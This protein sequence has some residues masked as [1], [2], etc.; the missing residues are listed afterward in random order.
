MARTAKVEKIIQSLKARNL[1][2]LIISH[3]LDQ[4]F[5]L[6][7]RICVLRRGKQIGIRAIGQDGQGRDLFDDHWPQR[8]TLANSSLMARELL[9]IP[10]AVEK[11]LRENEKTIAEI[12]K[13][14]H[15]V[16]PSHIITC[17]RGSSDHAAGYFKY[18]CEIV[19]GVPCCSI[20]PSVASVYRRRFYFAT[21]DFDDLAIRASPDVVAMQ[22]MAREAGIPTIAVTNDP[23]SPLANAR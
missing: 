6:A 22:V 13:V 15:R 20:G 11:S 9:E 17:A 4:V 5:R 16:R 14:F 10:Q 12:A 1:P 18:L 8:M 2:I 7:D 21:L 19:L 3:S 23:A